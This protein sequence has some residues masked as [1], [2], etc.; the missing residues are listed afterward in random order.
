[1]IS[2]IQTK[3]ADDLCHTQNLNRS[4]CFPALSSETPEPQAAGFHSTAGSRG[5]ERCTCPTARECQS[6]GAAA[7]QTCLAETC[8]RGSRDKGG[9]VLC[10]TLNHVTSVCT[11]KEKR[12]RSSH[13][14]Q[15]AALRR[16]RGNYNPFAKQYTFLLARPSQQP[17]TWGAGGQCPT[18]PHRE[19]GSLPLPGPKV[20]VAGS[21]CQLQ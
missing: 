12:P 5:P 20:T 2:S 18:W 10:V 9:R 16:Q 19:P 17:S 6:W 13:T 4:G 1:M 11:C 8:F 21:V 14:G 7:S 3:Q 15:E